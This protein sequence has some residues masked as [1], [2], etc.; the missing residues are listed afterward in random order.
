VYIYIYITIIIITYI[1]IIITIVT[2]FI[3][4]I[5]YHYH[6]NIYIYKYIHITDDH[7]INP[8][9]LIHPQLLGGG[10]VARHEGI[11]LAVAKDASLAPAA[12]GQ[13]AT[14]REDTWRTLRCEM[15][16]RINACLGNLKTWK[17]VANLVGST[18]ST[19][20]LALGNLKACF[21]SGST[22]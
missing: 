5:N 6:Y 14:C 12:L 18:S 4:I 3:I 11:A 16:R 13:Q 21:K 17:A 20:N 9:Q 7:P 22:M 10:C 1:N 19:M 15:L 8:S 2:I